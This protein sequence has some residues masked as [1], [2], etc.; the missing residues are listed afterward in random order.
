MKKILFPFSVSLLAIALVGVVGYVHNTRAAQQSNVT[1]FAWSSNI[2]WIKMNPLDDP[3]YDVTMNDATGAL[4][5]YAWSSN[6]GWIQFDPS[7]DVPGQSNSDPAN[8][9]LNGPNA[10]QVTGWMRACSVFVSGCSGGLKSSAQTGGW[11]G[12][13]EMSGADHISPIFTTITDTNGDD[14]G[15]G[16]VTYQA[17]NSRLI[18]YAWGGDVVGWMDFC[19]MSNEN[20]YCVKIEPQPTIDLSLTAPKA[21]DLDGTTGNVTIDVTA[22]INPPEVGNGNYTNFDYNC[23]NGAGSQSVPNGSLTQDTPTFDIVTFQCTYDTDPRGR[24]TITASVKRGS[25]YG[26]ASVDIVVKPPKPKFKETSP[27]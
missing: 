25:A 26:S 21:V 11:D 17:A 20:N 4:S 15:A 18:G 27:Q 23:D 5:G 19:N 12:W 24:R 13:I 6:I 2:G 3:A 9:T 22:T 7:D 1:G 8:V 14:H 10:G 16:G